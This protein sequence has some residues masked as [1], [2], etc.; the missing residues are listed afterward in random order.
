MDQSQ[1]A[2]RERDRRSLAV[3]LIVITLVACRPAAAGPTASGETS[4]SPSD[5]ARPSPSASP[6]PTA[7]PLAI[8]KPAVH[9]PRALYVAEYQLLGWGVT[10]A[11]TLDDGTPAVIV[12]WPG[13]PND[14]GVVIAGSADDVIG[15][16]MVTNDGAKM[17][18]FLFKWSS[19]EITQWLS[20][21]W[22]R[23]PTP[24]SINRCPKSSDRS[25]LTSSRQAVPWV[26][27]TRRPTE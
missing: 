22:A 25:R 2:L 12:R 10:D 27:L 9:V 19:T 4:A 15:L 17:A 7:T 3:I 20:I 8:I 23:W 26:Q 6:A 21:N 14:E 5:T 16:K 18:D 1:L 11:F 13:A 24:G